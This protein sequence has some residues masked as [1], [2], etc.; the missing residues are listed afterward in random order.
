MFISAHALACNIFYELEKVCTSIVAQ[1][2]NGKISYVKFD[3]PLF[4]KK[5]IKQM[6]LGSSLVISK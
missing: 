6:L 4:R 2:E 5:K 3:E 1:D